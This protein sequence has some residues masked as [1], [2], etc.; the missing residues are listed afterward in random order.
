MKSDWRAQNARHLKGLS[1]RLR[2]YR[3]PSESWD[4]DHRGACWAKLAELPE[5]DVLHEGYASDARYAG[6]PA[7]YDWVCP[8]CFRDLKDD[9][10]WTLQ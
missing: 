8:V 6:R 4:H 3:P 5:P 10:G 2:M 1:F 9:L 7:C